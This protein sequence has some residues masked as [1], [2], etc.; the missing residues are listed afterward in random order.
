MSRI[1]KLLL[2]AAVPGLIAAGFVTTSLA[3]PPQGK[4]EICH[5]ASGHKF[6][7]ISVSASAV[8]AHMAH[9]DVEMDTYG[10]CP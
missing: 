8:P 4:T 10:E 5:L 2:V 3:S 6:V 9:G 1:K 7:K